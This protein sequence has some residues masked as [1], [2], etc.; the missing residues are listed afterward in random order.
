M[1]STEDNNIFAESTE[2]PEVGAQN[3]EADMSTEGT[4]LFDHSAEMAAI[5]EEEQL[6]GVP[7][8]EPP[9]HVEAPINNA[10]MLE[11]PVEDLRAMAERSFNGTFDVGS[12]TVTPSERE[13]FLRA[14]LH[15]SELQFDIRLEGINTVVS[16]VI[17]PETFTT[18]AASAANAWAKLGH[19]D[20]DSDVQWVLS[21]QQMHVWFQ[22][23]AVNHTPTAWSDTF[24]DGMPK[25]SE[26][27]RQLA[28]PDNF[29]TFFTMQPAR[30]RMLV[31]ATRIAEY[32]YKL[33]QEAWH[34]KSFFTRAGIA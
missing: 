1:T 6:D 33:C 25:M 24:C 30:W 8:P 20:A 11:S 29:E 16:V 32:K 34:D 27:R 28:D 31:E 4:N 21:F 9:D 19:N 14:A 10:K 2:A 12:V 22:V 17:P 5:A 15:D 7:I 18:S 23:R 26:M 3:F 13:D